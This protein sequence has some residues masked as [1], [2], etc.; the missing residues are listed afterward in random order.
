MEFEQLTDEMKNVS[1]T[2]LLCNWPQ[3]N[4]A[5]NGGKAAAE[6]L[7]PCC[8]CVGYCCIGCMKADWD[9]HVHQECQK[10]CPDCN[11]CI[12]I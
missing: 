1:P 10:V 2:L 3:C 4:M 6:R 12:H 11:K 8:R 9:R 5:P 7:C